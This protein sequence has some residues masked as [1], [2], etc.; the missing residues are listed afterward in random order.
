MELQIIFRTSLSM[1]QNN[2]RCMFS[3]EFELNLLF[4][5][6]E[7]LKK[8]NGTCRHADLLKGKKSG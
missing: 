3:H 6:I 4:Y 8:L 7:L 1:H 2:I 5:Q